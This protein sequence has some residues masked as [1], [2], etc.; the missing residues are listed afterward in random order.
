VTRVGAFRF[1]THCLAPGAR[2]AIDSVDWPRVVQIASE[3]WMPLAL[4]R[5]ME[6]KG[7]VQQLPADLTEYF[8]CLREANRARNA[9][10]LDHVGEAIA[11]LNQISIEPLLLKGTANLACG[12]YPDPAIRYLNDI[13]LLVP[14]ARALECWRHL[15]SAGYRTEPGADAP[16]DLP[17]RH[18]PALVR[19]G[20]TAEVEI[21]RA[22]EW[23]DLPGAADLLAETQ[24]VTRARGIARIPGPTGRL[25][26]ALGHGFVQHRSAFRASARFRDLYDCLL[27][28]QRYGATLDWPRVVETFE[29]AKERTAL[30]HAMVMW[31]HLF[32]QNPPCR[33]ASSRRDRLYWQACLL[34]VAAP[35]LALAGETLWFLARNLRG[36][37][38]RHRLFRRSALL[39]KLRT[40]ARIWREV[41][42]NR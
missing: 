8:E 31:R 3:H 19:D 6:E 29:R 22:A 17:Y 9:A 33:L 14:D 27:L 34:D 37:E 42:T 25:I 21:H 20:R 23:P 30:S 1:L 18:W 15:I 11:L 26:F 10:I 28:T 4:Y 5:A 32:R 36:P 35:R 16:V 2:P 39:H 24:P 13:D 7:L 12:L 41:D 40:A 38:E